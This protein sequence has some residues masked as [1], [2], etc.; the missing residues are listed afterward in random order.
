MPAAFATS[1]DAERFGT[2]AAVHAEMVAIAR[3]HLGRQG[4]HQSLWFVPLHYHGDPHRD[5]VRDLGRLVPEEVPIMWTGPEICSEHLTREHTESVAS[6]LRRPVLYWDNHPVNDGPMRNDPHLNPLRGRDGDLAVAASG[7]LANLA[8]EPEA[9]LIAV[10]TALDFAR[11]PRTYDPD[12]SWRRA[13]VAV[14]GDRVDADAVATLAA[15]SPRSPLDR[16]A[17]IRGAL[18]DAFD[19]FEARWDIHP[20]QRREALED[21]RT[22]LQD[23]ADAARRLRDRLRN[24]RLRADLAPWSGKL[25]QLLEAAVLATDVLEAVRGDPTSWADEAAR[26]VVLERLTEASR[27]LH[28]VMGDRLEVFARGCL[29]R[30][31]ALTGGR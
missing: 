29:H 28:F 16:R 24:E 30:A 21:V 27:S 22:A 11:D 14:S 4:L 23:T 2:L 15:L 5:Y 31:D 20:S 10:A 6:S 8:I 26:D 19:R 13:L 18:A 3:D 25:C 7:L 9:S 17:P 12:E 1:T